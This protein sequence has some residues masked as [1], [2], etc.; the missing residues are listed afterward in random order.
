MDQNTTP[1]QFEQD[2]EPLICSIE[3]IYELEMIPFILAEKAMFK[4][5][6][7]VGVASRSAYNDFIKKSMIRCR[8]LVSS[9]YIDKLKILYF[10]DEGLNLYILKTINSVCND[11]I[12]GK[13]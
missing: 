4:E 11:Y 3:V 10:T 5:L 13:D 1:S 9:K 6:F 2:L 7:L 8:E 12:S